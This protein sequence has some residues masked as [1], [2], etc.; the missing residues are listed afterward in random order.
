MTWFLW[1]R[2]GMGSHREKEDDTDSERSERD[3]EKMALFTIASKRI[4]HVGI[5]LPK[6]AKGLYS[7]NCKVLMK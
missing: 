6:E 1:A 7:E 3:I 4:K 5:N 2:M